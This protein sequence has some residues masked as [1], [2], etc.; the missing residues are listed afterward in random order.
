MRDKRVAAP[1]VTSTRSGRTEE[2]G[3]HLNHNQRTASIQPAP[4]TAPGRR[5]CP[6]CAHTAPPSAFRAAAPVAGSPGL[7]WRVC[8]ACRHRG[9]LVTFRRE[10]AA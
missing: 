5:R 7:A 9:L 2:L 10:V 1:G 4:Q 8:P 3:S 6:I